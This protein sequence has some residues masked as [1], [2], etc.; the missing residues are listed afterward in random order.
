MTRRVATAIIVAALAAAWYVT[1][2]PRP[3]A[4]PAPDGDVM[5]VRGVFHVHTRR[6]DGTGTIDDVAR[7]AARAGLAFVILTDHGDATREPDRPTYRSGVLCIDAVEISTTGGHLVAL[8]LGRAPYPLGGEARDVLEDVARLGGMSIPAHPGSNKPEL[9]WTEWAAPFDGLEWLNGD[10]EWRDETPATLARVLLA[11]PARSAESLAL[12]LDRPNDILSRW[13]RLTQQHR[14]VAVAASDAHARLGLR[15]LGEP[16]DRSASLP[17]PGYEQLF[18]TFSIALPQVRLTGRAA[19]DAAAVLAEIRAGHVYSAIDALA[20]PARLSFTATSAGTQLITGDELQ[21]HTP[22][23][24]RVATNAPGRAEIRLLKNGEVAASTGD[25]M[26]EQTVPPMP[27][28][29]RVE[30]QLPGAP[31]MPSIPWIV[32]NPIY[33]RAADQNADSPQRPSP[34]TVAVQYANGPAAGWRI[35]KSDR[36]SAALDVVGAVPGTQLLMRYALGGTVAEGPFVAFVMPPGEQ[37]R[38]HNRL[39]FS[40]YAD[41]PMRLS[42]QVR[43]AQGSALERWHRSVYLDDTPRTITVFFDEMTPVGTTTVQR[44]PLDQV[45]SLLF[46]VDTVNTRP[47][48]SGQ[49]WIDDVKYGR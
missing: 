17:L 48:T 45:E 26:L 12:L 13:D 42:V 31:G 43:V 5:P 41:H 33:L 36:A 15:T 23:T 22:V 39:I 4:L 40:A 46:V 28:V 7:A 1:L 29:Y 2:P 49:I 32:S 10:S 16:Y 18:R 35:E 44:P 11:Y 27:G 34:T 37:L 25:A 47:G 30:V 8:G 20:A 3:L 21:P 38:N 24:L 6:S 9:Q 19:D 14:V